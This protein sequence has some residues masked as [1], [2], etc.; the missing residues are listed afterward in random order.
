[1]CCSKM[2]DLG[3]W[4][5]VRVGCLVRSR[6]QRAVLQLFHRVLTKLHGEWRSHQIITQFHRSVFAPPSATVLL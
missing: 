4:G 2:P 5:C 1:M 6:E 3:V